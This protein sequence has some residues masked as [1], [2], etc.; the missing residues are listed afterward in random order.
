MTAR[1]KKR[2]S[3]TPTPD[4]STAGPSPP[5]N[6]RAKPPARRRTTH[7][8]SPFLLKRHERQ[9]VNLETLNLFEKGESSHVVVFMPGD[10]DD[11]YAMIVYFD[12]LHNDIYYGYVK[13]EGTKTYVHFHLS[14]VQDLT[15]KG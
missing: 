7:F 10:D 13:S 5:T 8:W 6:P 2:H 9:N 14:Y 1:R 11:M 15:R 12:K 3:A 4:N